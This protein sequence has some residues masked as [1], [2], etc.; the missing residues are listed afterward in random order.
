MLLIPQI[1]LKQSKAVRFDRTVA[2][3]FSEDPIVMANTLKGSGVEA[4]YISDI[5]IPHVGQSPHLPII[6]EIREKVG[7]AVY[8]GGPF[9]SVGS[10]EPY[11]D[12]G[13]ELI[14]LGAVVYQQPHILADACKAFPGRVAAHIDV[15]GGRVTVPGW[16]VAANKPASEFAERFKQAGVRVLFYSD[17]GADGK[18]G[19]EQFASTLTFCKTALTRIVLTSD[20]A[21]PNDIERLIRLGAPRLE[22]L[23][24][25]KA[26]YE[27]RIDIRGACALVADLLLISG[28]EPTIGSE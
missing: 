28:N 27:G 12:L 8:V 17:V 9:V 2:P 23:V 10:M 25:A 24:V 14:A 15:K 22:G 4:V 16:T 7:L 3:Q 6:K 5:G 1:F 13:V 21:G 19:D 26:F 11:I 20:V 18:I